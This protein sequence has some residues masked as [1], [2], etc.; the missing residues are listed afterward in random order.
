MKDSFIIYWDEYKMPDHLYSRLV[1]ALHYDSTLMRPLLA[2]KC[3]RTAIVATARAVKASH[4][5]VLNPG[6][7]LP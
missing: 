5:L 3:Q 4:L 1:V 2:V 7:F 6:L